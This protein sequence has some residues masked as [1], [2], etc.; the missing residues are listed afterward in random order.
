MKAFHS[1]GFLAGLLLGSFLT[2]IIPQLL[3]L[4][5][6]GTLKKIYTSRRE[7]FS[8]LVHSLDLYNLSNVS[9]ERINPPVPKGEHIYLPIRG[10]DAK[11]QQIEYVYPPNRGKDVQEQQIVKMAQDIVRRSTFETKWLCLIILNEAYIKLLENWLCGLHRFKAAEV[12]IFDLSFLQEFAKE[13][14]WKLT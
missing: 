1:F 5:S 11:Q 14:S 3:Q 13:V 8:P 7:N 4:S 2:S 12:V 9:S 6:T 10:N